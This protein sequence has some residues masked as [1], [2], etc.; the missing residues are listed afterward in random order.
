[1]AK[2][3]KLIIKDEVNVRFENLD[4]ITRR[5]ISDKL[6]YFLPYAYHLPSY[7][8]GRWDGHIR[9]CDIGGRT[10]LNLLDRILPIIEDQDYEIDIEDQRQKHEFNFD[11]IDESLHFNKT[12]GKKHPQAGQPIVLRDYQVKTINSFLEQPQCLQEIATGAGKTI[13]TAT[14]S[15]LVQKYGRSIVIVPNKSLVTQTEEDYKTI[16]LDVGVYYGERKEFDKQ[17]TICTWQSL[18]VLLKKSKKYEVDIRIG[19]F[20]R[21]VVCVMVDEVHQAKA[22]VLKTLLTGPFSN[23]PIRWGLT[24]TIPKE[25]YEMASLQASLGEVIFKLSASELQEKGVLAKCHVNIMQTQD[26][27]VFSNYANELTHLVTNNERLGFIVDL[28]DKIRAKGNTLILVDRIKSGQMLEELIVDSVFI[29]GRTKMEDRAE[30][31]DEIATEQ[32]KVIIATYGVAAVGV[33]LPRIFNLVLLEPGKSFVRVIQSIGRG[34]RKAED[35]DH[36]EIWDITSTCKFSK[37]HLT[38]RKKF[39][40]E[41]NYPFTIEKVT[42]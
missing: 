15:Q 23:V 40:K 31:Y 4:V 10:Y 21:D 5:K 20:L 1:M 37:R 3:T 32:H 6:K 22:D 7:K 14:L 11:A 17:H 33:N 16:G 26:T 18:N 13:I 36:V 38:T 42:I 34:I 27:Q 9:F 2:V 35:K 30:E 29:Q 24:G 19:D 41:A 25:D 28:I 12:W 8:L 39:Y